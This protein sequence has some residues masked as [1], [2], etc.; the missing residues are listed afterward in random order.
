MPVT[1]SGVRPLILPIALLAALALAVLYVILAG[2]VHAPKPPAS[3]PHLTLAKSPQI[4]PSVAF[5]DAAGKRHL[6]AEFRGR[7]ILLN[8]WAPW[9]APCLRELPALA[10]LSR[11]MP[12]AKFAVVAVYVGRNG[13]G[14]AKSFLAE[15]GA[16]GLP[17]YVDTDIALVRAFDAYGLPLTVIIDPQGREIARS[18]GPG[19]WDATDAVAYMKTLAGG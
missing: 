11:S 17:V 14:D 15:H 3:L 4:V 2:P 9:C 16:A 5:S 10:E 7:T 8:L 6:L 13:A 19:E 12:P 18:L 1:L